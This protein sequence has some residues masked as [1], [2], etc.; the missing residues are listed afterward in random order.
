MIVHVVLVVGFSFVPNWGYSVFNE[1]FRIYVVWVCVAT[2]WH[3][4]AVYLIDGVN[5]HLI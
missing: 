1:F 4:L 3:F 2:G 5:D